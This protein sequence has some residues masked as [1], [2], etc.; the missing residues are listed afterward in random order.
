MR[1]PANLSE[2]NAT[3]G[4]LLKKDPNGRID[5]FR[6]DRLEL[7]CDADISW[8]IDGEFGGSRQDIR[9]T[10]MKRALRILVDPERLDK[11]PADPAQFSGPADR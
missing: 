9:F 7:H 1:R 11:L 3:V 5:W 2:F 10:G 8:T 6:T 4:S